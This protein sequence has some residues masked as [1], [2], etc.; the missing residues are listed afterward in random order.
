[1]AVRTT[2]E[3]RERMRVARCRLQ[4]ALIAARIAKVRAESAVLHPSLRVARLAVEGTMRVEIMIQQALAD[5][6][7]PTALFIGAD[8][9][10]SGDSDINSL[11]L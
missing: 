5:L 4:C 2:P 8:S 9:E 3:E 11:G 6:G 10:D 1:M 7:P